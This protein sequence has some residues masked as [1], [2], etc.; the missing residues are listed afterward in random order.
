[1]GADEKTIY[2]FLLQEAVIHDQDDAA[3]ACSPSAQ[4]L[5]ACPYTPLAS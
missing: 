4:D 5:A 3:E 2:A 1:M